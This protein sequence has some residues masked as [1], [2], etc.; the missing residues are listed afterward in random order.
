MYLI[1]K[2]KNME[3]IAVI[4]K[5]IKYMHQDYPESKFPD[6]IYCAVTKKNII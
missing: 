3:R 4:C 6:S 5:H 1:K 2:G